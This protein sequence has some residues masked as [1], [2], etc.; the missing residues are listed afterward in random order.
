MGKFYV[1]LLADKGKCQGNI[2]AGLSGSR[3]HI[4]FYVRSRFRRWR[5]PPTGS[6]RKRWQVELVEECGWRI[7]VAVFTENRKKTLNTR[8]GMTEP[9]PCSDV[10]FAIRIDCIRSVCQIDSSRFFLNWKFDFYFERKCIN[11]EDGHKD[12]VSEHII[13]ALLINL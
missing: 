2:Q 5:P 9:P 1:Q 12:S 8:C 11:Y 6:C 3:R 13:S 10:R 7:V 4:W